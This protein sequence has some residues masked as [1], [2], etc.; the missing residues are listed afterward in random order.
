MIE[1]KAT[2][3]TG[4]ASNICSNTIA[5]RIYLNGNDHGRVAVSSHWERAVGN[6][7]GQ[8]WHSVRCVTQAER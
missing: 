7:V 8:H 4:I 5:T 6:G 3:Q 1:Q 2:K